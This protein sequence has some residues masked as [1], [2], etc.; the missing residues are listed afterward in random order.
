MLSELAAPRIGI[1]IRGTRKDI[2]IEDIV[3][4]MGPR[5]PAAST[6]QKVF[7]QAFLFVVAQPRE[8]ADDIAKLERFR[9]AWETY[10]SD[11]TG[12]RGTVV[13]SLR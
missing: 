1:D 13:T 4:A 8:T 7:R 11:S 6:A 10:F 2:R 5:Q 12:G 9:S 3:A